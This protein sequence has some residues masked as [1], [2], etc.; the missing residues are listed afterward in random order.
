MHN[1]FKDNNGNYTLTQKPNLPIIVW[2]VLLLIQQFPLQEA[3]I[4]P[5][6]L[7]SFGAIFTWAWME[8]V[9][10]ESIFRRVLGIIVIIVIIYTRL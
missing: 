4:K 10:G 1:I 8:I 7:I 5:V 9:S 6:E 2:L 3:L